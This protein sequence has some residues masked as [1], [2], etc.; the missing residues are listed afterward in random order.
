MTNQINYFVLPGLHRVEIMGMSMESMMARTC[1]FFE[2]NIEQLQSKWRKR[3]VVEARYFFYYYAKNIESKT[4][5]ML[6]NAT[7]RDHTTIIHGLRTME[8]LFETDRAYRER[9]VRFVEF[10]KPEKLIAA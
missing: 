9:W 1:Q 10:M 2:V 7:N 3:E 8:N 6:G 4:L 5:V